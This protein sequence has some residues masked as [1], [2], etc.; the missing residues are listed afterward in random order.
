MLVVPAT[1]LKMSALRTLQNLAP[2]GLV[3]DLT[4]LDLRAFMERHGDAP[5]L[6]VRMPE[7]D[8]E[9]ELGLR[10][11]TSSTGT[12]RPAIAKPFPFRT[13]HQSASSDSRRLEEARRDRQA[14]L[15]QLLEKHAHFGL[16][17]SK[18][19][20]SD[21]LFMGQVSVGRAHN[22]DIV[23]RH[24]SVSKF[25]AWFEVDESGDVYVSDAGSTNLTRL[26]G[27]PMEPRT[28]MAVGPG[29]AIRFGAVE[30][31]LC[32]PETLWTCLRGD[33]ANDSSGA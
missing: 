28:R 4:T 13:T 20:G 30:A 17:L 22:K 14:S 26:N 31:V 18:R 2:P 24:S 15:G 33:K 25:H 10:A 19:E 8:T 12:G 27:Q 23:L 9:L 11:T 7:G 21:A 32:S 29:D 3:R 5:L 16:P 6:L 1:C